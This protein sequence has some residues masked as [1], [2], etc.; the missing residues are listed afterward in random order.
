MRVPPI[1]NLGSFGVFKTKNKKTVDEPTD[2]PLPIKYDSVTFSA[3]SK[4]IR[5]YETLPKE[6]KEILS[7]KDA[8]D[9]FQS[10]DFLMQGKI[11][12]KEIGHGDS[13]KVY[14]NPWLN[15]YDLLII[16]DPET[17]EQTIYS[18]N[19]LGDSVW[20]DRDNAAIQIIKNIS[21]A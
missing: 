4:Y 18:A 21:A 17:S 1:S 11:K 9:M 16:K 20:Y 2:K 6:I 15:G 7:P 5:K 14:E 8:I 3:K 12:G 19:T 10:I 13:S